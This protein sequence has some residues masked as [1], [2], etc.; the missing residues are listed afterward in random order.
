MKQQQG[1]QKTI[2]NSTCIVTGGAGFIG[3]NLTHTL[4]KPEL[5]N[6][7]I[8][9]D[10]L[11]TGQLHNIAGRLNARNYKKEEKKE[12][13][14]SSDYVTFIKADIRNRSLLQNIFKKY[15]PDYVFH[16]VAKD[17]TVKKQMIGFLNKHK[18]LEAMVI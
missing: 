5:D 2:T 8:V 16:L 18:P 10:N 1:K 12:F 17:A 15:K 4:A 9:T 6:H 3:S 7:V 11:S 14:L 13:T